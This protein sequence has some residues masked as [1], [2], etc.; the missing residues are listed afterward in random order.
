MAHEPAEPID[1]EDDDSGVVESEEESVALSVDL[2]DDLSG[3][4][5][6]EVA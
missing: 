2:S 5:A 3:D 1:L 6:D 4:P